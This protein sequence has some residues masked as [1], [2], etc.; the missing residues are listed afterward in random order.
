MRNQNELFGRAGEGA[1][2]TKSS[3]VSS[4]ETKLLFWSLF[5]PSSCRSF[6]ETA[7]VEAINPNFYRLWC[8]SN[9]SENDRI[10]EIFISYLKN[11]DTKRVTKSKF[12]F[13]LLG[14]RFAVGRPNHNLPTFGFKCSNLHLL[15]K[16]QKQYHSN[17][18]CALAGLFTLNFRNWRLCF[19]RVLQLPSNGFFFNSLFNFNFWHIICNY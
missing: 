8:G 1:K 2:C 17:Y 5:S 14:Q 16:F 4:L 11:I 10:N 13:C 7:P 12:T 15:K 6:L 18:L 3:K 9:Y 19:Y